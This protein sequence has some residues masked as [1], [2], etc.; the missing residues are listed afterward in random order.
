MKLSALKNDINMIN[1][2]M[3]SLGTFGKPRGFGS[4]G[5]TA[6][7]SDWKP[8]KKKKKKNNTEKPDKKKSGKKNKAG[9]NGYDKSGMP[10]F[11][12]ERRSASGQMPGGQGAVGQSVVSQGAAEQGVAN[13]PGNALRQS[14]EGQGTMNQARNA[15]GRNGMANQYAGNGR[16]MANRY[17]GNGRNMTNR[18]AGNGSG[19]ANRYG[20]AYGSAPAPINLQE[21][22]VWAEILGEPVSK[23]RRR[24]RVSWQDGN[25]GNADRR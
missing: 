1:M 14:A 2:R 6:V 12:D 13:R 20:A 3:N 15:Q 19:M 21:A 17:A 4:G 7:T 23:R 18:Y 22:V 9:G 5:F 10:S 25:Q 11:E 16:S 8:P 24:R